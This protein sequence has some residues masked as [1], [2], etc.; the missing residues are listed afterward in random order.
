MNKK[1]I[2]ADKNK[3]ND[4]K[5]LDD[6]YYNFGILTKPKKNDNSEL[7]NL[8][9]IPIKDKGVNAPKFQ[10]YKPMMIQQAD[11]L[12]MP[13]DNGHK[14]ALV[15][16]DIGSRKTD[17]IPLKN[18]DSKYVLDG[19]K[20]IYN[21]DILKKPRLLEVDSGTEFKGVVP[22]YMKKNN[23]DLKVTKVGRHK[24]MAIVERRNQMIGG[25][26][27]KRQ[28][29]QELLTGE[30]S[31]EW[32]D[33]L[34]VIIKSMNRQ[35]NKWYQNQPEPPIEPVCHGDSCKLLDIGTKVRVK[36]DQP[37]DVTTGKRLHGNFRTSDI[38]WNPKH[39]VIKE[40]LLRP[41]FPPQYLLDGNI[42]NRKV[43]P[44]AYTKNELQVISNNE[45]Q[46]DGKL[47]V[48][49]KPTK[50]IIDKI[51]GDKIIKGQK[52]ALVKWK[53]Y[54]DPTYESYDQIKKDSPQSISD[55]ENNN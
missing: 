26:A 34:P 18:K 15:V 14:Y 33:D 2:N 17:A 40:V 37:L 19:F 36:L 38:R 8:Y 30:P 28:T 31:T 39:R 1:K 52:M 20:K 12:F 3:K 16:T 49:G 47:L 29:A 45:S 6:F 51:I 5:K 25:A 10:Q 41:G 48:R 24:Q 13:E 35:A 46:P 53:G 21:R 23:I 50:F 27:H 42:G 44:I 55:Y 4:T 22:N 11:L 9:K 7:A 32:I 43:E 54:K